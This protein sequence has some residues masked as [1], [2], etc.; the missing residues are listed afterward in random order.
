MWLWDRV[1]TFH[2]DAFTQYYAM[3]TQVL[4]Y[5]DYL[6]TLPD[7]VPFALQSL[8]QTLHRFIDQVR[9]VGEK[10]VE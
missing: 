8:L 7:E 9:L 4:Y 10:N 2:G 1:N 5:Y 6:L 3:A